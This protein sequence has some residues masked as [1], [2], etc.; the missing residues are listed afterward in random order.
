MRI[1]IR[2]RHD[3]ITAL[4]ARRGDTHPAD[5]SRWYTE[6]QWLDWYDKYPLSPRA[7]DEAVHAW[8]HDFPMHADTVK[9]LKT[10]QREDT[11]ESKKHAKELRNGAFA[12]Y[13]RDECINEQLAMSVLK[14]PSKHID[15]LVHSWARHMAGAPKGSESIGKSGSRK[16]PSSGRKTA[17]ASLE[18]KS[19]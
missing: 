5:G 7:M 4:G 6:Q 17:P 16:Y 15:H 19:T 10:W 1:P 8:K 18:S 3:F 13:L 9:K 12:V 2:C 11:R 14:F